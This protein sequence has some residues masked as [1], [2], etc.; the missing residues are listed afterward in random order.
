MSN[1]RFLGIYKEE[2]NEDV[3]LS[4]LAMKQE[5]FTEKEIDEMNDMVLQQLEEC[6]ERLE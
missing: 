4:E 1:I 3:D 6:G 2:I 5:G